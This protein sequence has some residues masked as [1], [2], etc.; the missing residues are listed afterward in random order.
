MTRDEAD[1]LC[2]ARNQGAEGQPGVRWLV[3]ETA[4]G[5]WSPVRVTIPG[6]RAKGPLKTTTEARPRPEQAPDPRPLVNP[7]WGAPG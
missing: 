1:Q 4:P 3:R 5:D 7:N 6:M 2:A